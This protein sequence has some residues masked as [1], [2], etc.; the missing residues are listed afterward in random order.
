MKDKAKDI[1]VK[2]EQQKNAAL[3]AQ[4][5][6]LRKKLERKKMDGDNRPAKKWGKSWRVVVVKQFWG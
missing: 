2:R 3:K 1:A 6:M 4:C 5:R